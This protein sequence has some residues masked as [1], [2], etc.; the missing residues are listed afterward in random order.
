[1]KLHYFNVKARAE[2]TRATL[3]LAKV[4]FEDIRFEKADWPALKGK[5]PLGQVPVLEL[6]DGTLLPQSHAILKYV[7]R[8]YNFYPKDAMEAYIVDSTL[9]SLKDLMEKVVKNFF[10]TDEE[11]KKKVTDEILTVDFPRFAK[12]LNDRIEKN[13]KKHFIAGD[14]L[15][16]ADIDVALVSFD[17]FNEKN[18]HHEALKAIVDAN[19]ALKHFCEH[20]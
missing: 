2:A 1:M 8:L 9:D 5:F 11:S 20:H 4:P 19:P 6:E 14:S 7:G 12:F 10:N 15:S 16:V 3:H 18:P 17:W 13:G